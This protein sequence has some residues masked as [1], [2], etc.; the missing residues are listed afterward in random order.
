MRERNLANGELRSLQLGLEWFADGAGGGASRVMAE[1]V[2]SLPAAGVTVRGAVAGPP[3][4]AALT[5]GRVESFAPRSA[6]LDGRLIGAR[7][8]VARL[9]RHGDVDVVAA[10]FALYIA[11]CLDRLKPTPLVV[12]F[13]GPWAA[14]SRCEGQMYAAVAAKFAVERLVYRRAA[15]VIVLSHAFAEL[16]RRDYGVPEDRLRVVPG[17][18]DLA[19]FAVP[20]DETEARIRLGWPIDRKLLLCVRRLSP[21]M[22]L[23]RLLEAMPR[24]AQAEP[25]V[26]L[27]IAGRGPQAEALQLQVERLDLKDHVKLLGFL[28][29]EDLPLAYRAADL[30]LVP[31]TELEGFGMTAVEALAAG[32][33]SMVTPVGGLPEVVA[34]LSPNLLFRSSSAPDM[35]EGLI[36]VLSGAVPL[37]GAEA[38]ASYAARHFAAERMAS[39]VA[40][41]YRELC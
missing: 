27:H 40:A 14:E 9:L 24:V 15:R 26:L 37:P 8:L 18:V 7:K 21:R 20:E 4:V 12:H 13:H 2:R 19:R 35:A 11:P 5:G 31:T 34:G 39:A 6:R 32:T 16:A 1:L 17:S 25:T 22:G 28:R 29:D 38:C 3:D 33:P 36:R 10:H 23:D 30:N 41:V